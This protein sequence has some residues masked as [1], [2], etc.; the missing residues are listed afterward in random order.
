MKTARSKPF[1]FHYTNHK[2]NKALNLQ[3]KHRIQTST[4]FTAKYESALNIIYEALKDKMAQVIFE[5]KN[6]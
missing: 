1:S 4:I 3:N 2:L 5:V 6:N